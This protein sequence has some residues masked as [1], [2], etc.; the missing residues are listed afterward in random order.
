VIAAAVCTALVGVWPAVTAVTFVSVDVA[1]A[2]A[3]TAAPPAD[4]QEPAE[5]K[6][7][8]A[9]AADEAAKEPADTPTQAKKSAA[10]GAAQQV[11]AKV[12]LLFGAWRPVLSRDTALF[13]LVIVMGL[14]G[15]LVYVASSFALHSS[16]RD[17][18]VSYLWWYPMRFIGGTG[19]ALLLYTALRG[20]LFSGDF[21]NQEINPYGIAAAAGITGMFSKQATAKLA[22]LFDVAFQIGPTKGP[23]KIVALEPSRIQVGSKATPVKVTGSGL[24]HGATV[25]ADDTPVKDVTYISDAELNIVVPADL[26]TA[27]RVIKIRVD[28]PGPDAGPSAPADLTVTDGRPERATR[29][30]QALRNLDRW[31]APRQ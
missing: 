12:P 20:G 3:D 14:L 8:A 16:Q 11:G 31:R 25:T 4:T 7:D 6:A 21:N 27:P 18:T 19:L 26:L 15:S 10:T 22:Q 17:L 30:S 13:V 24:V 1:T 29:R 28:N 9:E 5:A 2:T 23:P